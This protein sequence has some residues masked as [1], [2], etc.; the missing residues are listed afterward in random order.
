MRREDAWRVP[1]RA[2]RRT[3][4]ARRKNQGRKEDSAREGEEK[5][6]KRRAQE[7]K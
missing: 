1:S 2:L 5:I 4:L 3:M 7:N 6:L